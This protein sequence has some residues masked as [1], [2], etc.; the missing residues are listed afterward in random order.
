MSWFE[1]FG[2]R[3]PGVSL[4]T[5][6][7]ELTRAFVASYKKQIEENPRTLP[8]ERAKP[9]AF[10]GPVLRDRG[11]N[12]GKDAKVAT[13]LVGGAAMGL[14][15]AC[16]NVANLMLARA[17]RRRREFAVRIALGVSRSRLVMQLIT[18]SLILALLGGAA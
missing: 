8:I 18:E 17:L 1:I 13:W 10:P 5:A 2:R 9:R 16:A 3:K 6:T 15:I 7:A 12:E 4:E 14:L 11:P